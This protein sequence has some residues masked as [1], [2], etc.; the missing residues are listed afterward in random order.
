MVL[1]SLFKKELLRSHNEPQGSTPNVVFLE[2]PPTQISSMTVQELNALINQ[3]EEIGSKI[4]TFNEESQKLFNKIAILCNEIIRL[5]PDEL[6]IARLANAKKLDHPQ[7]KLIRSLLLEPY[8]IRVL[9]K[10][11]D[12]A[13]QKASLADQANLQKPHPDQ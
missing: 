3:M 12:H 1:Q 13:E 10:K 11:L 5:D 7:V 9:R 8:K 6:Q 4:E 2:I